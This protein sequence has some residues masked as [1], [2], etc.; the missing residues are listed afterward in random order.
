MKTILL[1]TAIVMSPQA[2]SAFIA[3]Q[4][5]REVYHHVDK[6]LDWF[7]RAREV[8]TLRRSLDNAKEAETAA[9]QCIREAQAA[10]AFVNQVHALAV[11]NEICKDEERANTYIELLAK[12]GIKVVEDMNPIQNTCVGTVNSMRENISDKMSL[13]QGILD[14][15]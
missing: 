3:E 4:Q 15:S 1:V 9:E 6:F 2:A 14:E 7:S 8:R 13:C 5:A 12:Y 11:E 10:N